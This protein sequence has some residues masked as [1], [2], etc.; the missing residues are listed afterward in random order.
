MNH[1][2][3]KYFYDDEIDRFRNLLGNY[4]LRTQYASKGH[5]GSAAHG[6]G[7]IAGSPSGAYSTSP[8][9]AKN[10]K[11]SGQA[12]GIGAKGTS[13]GIG[14]GDIN[15]RDHAGVP[16]LG[17][18]AS[19]KSEQAIEF[20]LALIEH[21]AIDLYA[22]DI[23]NGW[24]ALHRALY[25]GNI[26]LARA[27]IE[28]DS[29]NPSGLENS[30]QKSATSIIKVKDHEGNSPFDVY[31]ATIARQ[32]LHRDDSAN[33]SDDESQDEEGPSNSGPT[34]DDRH[35]TAPINGDELFAWGSN[36]NYNLGLGD[37]DDRQWPEKVGL[38]R[39]DHILFRLYREHL[40]SVKESDQAM[41]ERLLQ[42]NPRSVSELPTLIASR[43]IIIQDAVLSKLHS[44]VLTEQGDLF[45]CGFGPGGRL[46]TGDEITR[47]SYVC[48]EGG[49][50]GK[51]IVQVALGHNH[52][53]AVD[54]N[55]EVFSWGQSNH[56][57]LGYSLPRTS[58][59]D[60]DP[61]C[62]TPRQ[63]FGPLKRETIIGVAASSIHSV[64]HTSTSLF[65]WGRNEGQL[66]LMDSDS[67]SLEIQ[68][69][70]RKVAASLF[71]SPIAA[72]AAINRATTVLLENHAVCVFT[73]YGYKFL[74][75]PPNDV[76]RNHQLQTSAF[77]TQY[78]VAADNIT[79]ITAAGETIAA[80]STQSLFTVNVGSVD[81]LSETSTTNPSKIRD[82][83]PD[84]QRVW[85]LRKGHWDG[86]KSASVTE[87]G[88]VIVCTQA[89]AVWRRVK[90]TKVKDAFA[91]TGTFHKNDFKFQRV[92]GLTKVAAV[93]STAFGVYAAI[94]KDCDVTRTQISVSEESFCDDIRPLLCLNGLEASEMS[95]TEDTISPRFWSPVLQKDHLEPLKRAVLMSPDLETDV[96]QH[97][98]G[99]GD[100]FDAVIG[101]TTSE[102]R[103]PVHGFIVAR[104]SILRGVLDTFRRRGQA[105]IPDF[106][107]ITPETPT[108]SKRISV[109]FQGLD[110]LTI[111]NLVIYLYTDTIVDVWQYTRHF[112]KMAFRYR[113]V[114]VELM[115]AAA[116]LGLAK[117]ESAVRLMTS[118]ER[119]LNLDMGL[120][121]EDPKYFDD[122]DTIIELDGSELFAH[123]ALLCQ[124]CPF[125]DG[126]FNG[127]AGG[128]W[129]AGRR[130]NESDAVR[131][132]LKH[133]D[134]QVFQLVLR[135]LY[136][137]V[138]VELF[139]DL[140]ADDLDEF[141]D[142][143]MDVMAVSNE[144]MLDRLSEIC[145]EVIGRF[146]NT[147]NVCHVLNAVAPCSITSF[148][149]AALE[150]L[151]LQLE[152]ML[153]NHLLNN[154]DDELLTELDDVVR[155]NQNV[156]LPFSKGSQ[157]EK[158]LSLHERDV[159][160]GD[161]LIEE[162]RRRISDMAFRAS[163]KLDDSRL[164]SS[165]RTA[166]VG[167]LE[168]SI[169][170]S[171]SQEKA[172]RKIK[173]ARN[174]PFSPTIRAKDS[175]LDLMFDMEDDDALP[176]IL[177]KNSIAAKEH[178]L[179]NESAW[180]V[181]K[182]SSLQDQS[183]SFNPANSPNADDLKTP[184]PATPPL[185]STKTWSSPAIPSSK[186]GLSE[187]MAQAASNRTSTLSMSLSAQKTRDETMKRENL[188]KI[189]QKE[190]KRQHQKAQQEKLSSPQIRLDETDDKPSS[191]WQVADRGLKTSLRDV[192]DNGSEPIPATEAKILKTEPIPRPMRRAA[193]PD[194]RFSGQLRSS[195][196]GNV[197]RS[198]TATDLSQRQPA[199]KSNLSPIL[200][201]S[202]SYSA[203]A[204]KAEPTLQLS[205]A[206]IIGQQ[207]R[208]QEVI[209]E[210][211][212]KRSLQE[213]QEEQAFQEWWDQES[214]R[215]QEQEAATSKPTASPTHGGKNG[216]GRGKGAGRGRKTRG[217]RSNRGR[218]D[219]LVATPAQGRGKD[220]AT[221]VRL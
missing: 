51:K 152:S 12:G 59:K 103:I 102:I 135:H 145:Q 140:V 83:L 162:R 2:L 104:S 69:V 166:R 149:D 28:R 10:R 43:P 115:K 157:E 85:S 111:L 20:G 26:Y 124:R 150:Y 126:L 56:G 185:T 18:I 130:N 30:S 141:S 216:G 175:T 77:T 204:T 196:S 71:K 214:R 161:D 14:R 164:S 131:I 188:A 215:A 27:M 129:L 212:A 88:S 183:T 123:S 55:G 205:M 6:I 122:G 39:P 200:P 87:N 82:S 184:N 4:S 180:I 113:Q 34:D 114:R 78:G 1:L 106:L 221:E 134:Q 165:A 199:P 120:A 176:P 186:L 159:N 64:A 5:G 99:L 206:D 168:G 11:V 84:P 163:L 47:F 95:Q 7:N 147:R 190:R 144:L 202:K 50:S 46:G 93:R 198:S 203:P 143:V 79:S 139:D 110:F 173:A 213:I 100:G 86:I 58:F 97:L 90:R 117:L 19:S 105:T 194:T 75:F 210:A 92:P 36:K 16:L 125:F 89:G 61:I 68:A 67:R 3:W 94:R 218:G 53:M 23:E 74:K 119:R 70:P 137:D 52:S 187:I 33:H 41:Y 32:S 24:T 127:R 197:S 191:P 29:Q 80:Y 154:L 156:C 66:G 146:I 112:P 219:S 155:A 116:H 170:G 48:V 142:V 45:M 192:L 62:A 107:T 13:Q 153:E 38:K 201:H 17:R 65:T 76:F 49:I 81:T 172:Q 60:E 178:N 207:R 208:E 160:L 177:H 189:S 22:Q 211:V 101:S 136:A 108:S 220:K 171:P 57:V 133:V 209:K 132:D 158:L 169:S 118:P 138:G 44:A 195:S 25:F 217:G 174:V 151:C 91:G 8:R 40:E 37:E 54:A 15:G 42:A 35:P 31:N 193:S 121:I 63:I 9:V 109:I 73:A 148:K 21:P 98:Y 167:S 128:S 96:S 182:P 72:V 181:A 179:E